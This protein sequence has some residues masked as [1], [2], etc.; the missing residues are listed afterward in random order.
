MAQQ[1]IVEGNDGYVLSALCLAGGLNSPIGYV[2]PKNY[3]NFVV[4]AGGISRVSDAIKVALANPDVTN[5]GVVV[6]ANAVGCQSR[7]DSITNGIRRTYPDFN[8]LITLSPTGWVGEIAQGVALG[9]WVMPNNQD[10]GYLEHF[11]VRLIREND[12]NF[13][14]AQQFLSEA[15][16]TG[17]ASFTEGR[18][19]KAL[20]AL[21][22]AIQEEPGMNAPTAVKKGILDHTNPLAQNFLT[23]FDST[24]QQS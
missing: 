4:D 8:E 11:L 10:S 22:L 15:K 1:F 17:E 16:A 2:G 18:D 20:L 13:V 19:Q 14:L 5:I 7:I 12:Q 23:W 24:F 6:D 3:K 21:F 9:L